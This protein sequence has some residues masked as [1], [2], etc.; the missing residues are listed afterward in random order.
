MANRRMFSKT[1]VDSDE[2]LDMPISARLL[3]YDLGMRA[4]DDGFVSPKRVMR[5]S[6]AA[7]D[8]LRFLLAKRYLIPFESGVIVIRHWKMH[9][10]IRKDRYT[11]TE[12]TE[13]KRM[14]SEK[15]GKYSLGSGMTPRIP[16]VNLGKERLGKVI[17]QADKSAEYIPAKE[18]PPKEEPKPDPA[19]QEI[20]AKFEVINP[21]FARLFSNKSERAAVER[22]IKIHGQECVEKRIDDILYWREAPFSLVITKPT[23]L[24]NKWAKFDAFLNRQN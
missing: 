10:L 12:H 8:D 11:R 21:S 13:E 18:K 7:D 3:Y 14:L 20:I 4:D 23:E 15:D 2:F 22:L 1:I 6:G 9:N 16:A 5:I 17:I 19:V 24:E